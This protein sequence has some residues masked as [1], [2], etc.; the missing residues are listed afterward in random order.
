M[1]VREGH[2]WLVL[3]RTATVSL[4]FAKFR[5]DPVY[6]KVSS[7]IFLLL[8]PLILPTQVYVM[9]LHLVFNSV[10]PFSL[11]LYLNYAIYKR[12]VG[13]LHQPPPPPPPPPPSPPPPSPLRP[14]PPPPRW[15]RGTC[16]GLLRASSAGGRWRGGLRSCG[17]FS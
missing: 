9:W 12:L 15:G 8:L 7:S 14:S 13:V 2:L 5:S 16:G 1:V 17:W 11:L 10:L 6:I 3:A 4:E